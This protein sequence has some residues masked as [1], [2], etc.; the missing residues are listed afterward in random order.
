M[1]RPQHSKISMNSHPLK[2]CS[3]CL[4]MRVPEGGIE[5]GQKWICGACW[6]AKNSK[7]RLAK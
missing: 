7:K 5:M 3:K 4:E 6:I 2:K 1:L